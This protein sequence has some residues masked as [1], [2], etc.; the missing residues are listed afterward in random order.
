MYLSN[1]N[2]QKTNKMEDTKMSMS[3]SILMVVILIL[4]VCSFANKVSR[5]K[6]KKRNPRSGRYNYR[7]ARYTGNRKYNWNK[8][9]MDQMNRQQQQFFMEE[10]LKSV[11]PWE[12]GGYDMNCGNS[13]NNFGNGMF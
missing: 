12:M 6:S 1:I 9:L 4:K 10:G 13:F 5:V 7:N 8:D 2:K 3:V 11:T